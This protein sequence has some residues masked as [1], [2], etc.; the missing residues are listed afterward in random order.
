M[1]IPFLNTIFY[2]IEVLAIEKKGEDIDAIKTRAKI[3]RGKKGDKTMVFE[4]TNGKQI[5]VNHLKD[6]WISRDLFGAPK[7]FFLPLYKVG[8]MYTPLK[9]NA[10]E[11]NV[12]NVNL[13]NTYI[14]EEEK[15]KI[16]F[17][18]KAK[19]ADMLISIVAIICVAAIA[20]SMIMVLREMQ[21]ILEAMRLAQEQN[22]HVMRWIAEQVNVTKV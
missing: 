18:P 11:L 19:M 12:P 16:R 3:V 9:L 21:P 14:I 20:I 2:P 8:E 10:D 15:R 22:A 5:S 1:S 4:L 6:L 13:M 17:Q 7:K